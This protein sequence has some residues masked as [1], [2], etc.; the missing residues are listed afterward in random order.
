MFSELFVTIITAIIIG[1]IVF[2]LFNLVFTSR[3]VVSDDR[4]VAKVEEYVEP[5]QVTAEP[6]LGAQ[7]S[8]E[9]LNTEELIDL[10]EGL[11][12]S[13]RQNEEE[14][15]NENTIEETIERNELIEEKSEHKHIEPIA[16]PIVE[17][18]AKP[19]EEVIEDLIDILDNEFDDLSDDKPLS[20]ERN[21]NANK[22]DEPIESET[23]FIDPEELQTLK[24]FNKS[25]PKKHKS[26]ASVKMV[27]SDHS[28]SDGSAEQISEDPI[29]KKSREIVENLFSN[30]DSEVEEYKSRSNSRDYAIN[31]SDV[32]TELY[33]QKSGSD[34]EKRES[35]ERRESRDETFEE[36][37]SGEYKKFDEFSDSFHA[38]TQKREFSRKVCQ[39]SLVSKF[40][41]TL[42]SSERLTQQL[43]DQLVEGL[44]ETSE[45]SVEVF[46]EN[47]NRTTESESIESRNSSQSELL[48][49]RSHENV[50]HTKRL[51][52]RSVSNTSLSKISLEDLESSLKSSKTLKSP[53]S[54][55][56]DNVTK[57]L[58][59]S[60]TLFRKS[61]FESSVETEVER[62]VSEGPKRTTVSMFG[63][64]Q[65]SLMKEM[66]EKEFR[67][68]LKSSTSLTDTR[69]SPQE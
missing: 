1:L 63:L 48:S 34:D 20:D 62:S 37:S 12:Q 21:E 53:L 45:R 67:K 22:T 65:S 18:I 27:F 39:K 49:T 55:S 9:L 68:S 5:L 19:E 23:D 25:R 52:E 30:L 17:L 15:Q 7:E 46:E 60:P 51:S 14:L 24:H 54:E 3:T 2:I 26:R 13:I 43:L 40:E 38:E 44:A 4:E 59:S 41:I 57:P 33:E 50:L 28:F 69:D 35:N 47:Y 16:E 32:L 10:S 29:S 58:L 31:E 61:F 6:E 64:S 42:D 56:I 36:I 66:K 11:N 8:A